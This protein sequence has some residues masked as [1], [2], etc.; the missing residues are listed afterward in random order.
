MTTVKDLAELIQKPSEWLASELSSAGILISDFERPLTQFEKIDILRFLRQAAPS[1]KGREAVSVASDELGDQ[2]LGDGVELELDGSDDSDSSLHI[3]SP[4]DPERIRVK[5]VNRTV[6]L[7]IRRIGHGEIDVAPEFQRR[8][9]VW[10]KRRKS[11]LI[12]SLLLRIPLPVFYVAADPAENWAVVDGLQRITTILD[13]VEGRYPLY[14]LE[15]LEKFNGM[16]FSDLPRQ[17]QRRIEETELVIHVIEPGTPE[18]VMINIFK[19]INTGGVSLNGQEIRNALNRGP[20]RD[21][22]RKLSSSEA[23]LRATDGSVNDNRMD[24]QEC[25]LRFCAFH[26]DRYE[27]YMSN[28]LDGF[29][30]NAMKKINE[31]N[32]KDRK[33]LGRDFERAMDAA[34]S[35][36]GERAFRKIYDVEAARRHPVSKA[37]F[38]SWSV[39]L[40]R[41]SDDQIRTLA[42]RRKHLI[43]VFSQEINSNREFELSLSYSTGSAQRVATRFYMVNQ[44]ILEAL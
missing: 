16:C 6:D 3:D 34:H 28:D 5:T 25:V 30:S 9:R 10:D 17:I 12:E 38:E 37:L 26:M 39:N 29:L 2:A 27:K 7:V 32:D 43:R 44:I 35:I 8:A 31:L 19:R 42:V 33:S 21:F 23:F 4:F 1:R 36:F 18:S 20:V 11:R 41:R 22:L 40:A 13:F 14:E 24:A 15:Y